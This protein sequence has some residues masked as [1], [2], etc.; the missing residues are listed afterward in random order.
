[1][2]ESQSFG[3]VVC[4]VRT[5]SRRLNHVADGEPLDGLIL[6]SAS[7]AVRAPDGLNVAAAC[8]N[9]ELAWLEWSWDDDNGYQ[10]D[11]RHTL[12]VAAVVLSLLNHLVGVLS[13]TGSQEGLCGGRAQDF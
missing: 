1:M 2:W 6:G 3:N 11:R 7:R 12:L 9:H 10:V 8:E 13:C 4:I 5:D